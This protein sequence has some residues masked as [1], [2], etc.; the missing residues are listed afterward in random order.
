[1]TL[2]APHRPP[3]HLPHEIRT[4]EVNVDREWHDLLFG[5]RRSIRYH[6]RR[7][8][9]FE[10]WHLM[11]SFLS[12]LLSSATVASLLTG[13]SMWGV[14]A[15]GIVTLLSALDLVVGTATRARNHHDLVRRFTDVEREMIG[16]AAP[17][18][19]DVARVTGERLAIEADEPP[20]KRVLDALCH[21]ELARAMGYDRSQFVPVRWWQRWL[22]QFVD[23]GDTR[24]LVGEAVR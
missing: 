12:V 21:N 14:V 4:T 24:L 23:V 2:S 8:Q 19:E 9:F 22:A 1:M 6:S 15:A 20:V 11:T 10:R 13:Q 17:T 7:R 16:I 5:V 18:V 3:D